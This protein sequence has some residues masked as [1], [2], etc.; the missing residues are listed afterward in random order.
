[1][2]ECTF[3]Y[4]VLCAWHPFAL[5]GSDDTPFSSTWSTSSKSTIKCVFQRAC[6]YIYYKYPNRILRL[7]WIKSRCIA[8]DFAF[9]YVRHGSDI[10]LYAWIHR[11]LLSGRWR[12]RGKGLRSLSHQGKK[13]RF[14]AIPQLKTSH[15]TQKENRARTDRQTRGILA[16]RAYISESCTPCFEIQR[17]VE[18][19]EF[20]CK[21]GSEER[22]HRMCNSYTQTPWHK[23][24]AHNRRGNG[25]GFNYFAAK[26]YINR[27]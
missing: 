24:A 2:C 6:K 3:E 15:K 23:Q 27:T 22:R 18:W 12:G 7:H 13:N 25:C 16:I 1:M 21:P 17:V 26:S 9:V 14:M 19:S 4:I 10:L 11:L 8:R 20:A 5:H